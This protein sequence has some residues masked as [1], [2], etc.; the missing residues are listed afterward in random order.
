[1]TFTERIKNLRNSIRLPQRKLA[2]ALDID[3][4]TYCKI[5]RGERKANIDQVNTLASFYKINKEALL[6]LWLADKVNDVVSKNKNVAYDALL[7][8]AEKYKQ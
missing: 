7:I 3:T 2:E 1:M 4:A 5:E 8:A 6:T